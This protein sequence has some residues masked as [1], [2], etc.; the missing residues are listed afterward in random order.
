MTQKLLTISVLVSG[1]TDT[2]FRCLD[3]LQPLMNTIDSELIL[4]DTGCDAKMRK[5]LETYADKIISFKWCDDFSKARNVGLTEASGKWFLYLDDDEWFVEVQ[6]LIDF[7]QSGEYRNYTS[8]SYIQRNYLDMEGS[9]FTD[10][11]VG[12]MAQI[13]PELHFQSRIHEYLTPVGTRNKN[14]TATVEHYGYVYATEKQKLDHF[15]RNQT[16]LEEMIKE[17]PDILRWRL[18]LLQ[19][20]R[21]ID[22]YTQMEQLGADGIIK[23]NGSD[24]SDDEEA[25]VY[26][27]SFYAARILAAEGCKDYDRMYELCQIAAEDKRNTKLCQTF[28]NEMC[29]KA[30]FYLGLHATD[31][32][33]A[34]EQYI[35]SE[36]YAQRYLDFKEYFEKNKEEFYHLQI[37][38]FVG[39][40][41]DQVKVKEIYSIRICNGLKLNQENNLKIFIER[42][43]WDEKHVYVFEEIVGILIESMENYARI[44]VGKAIPEN[45]EYVVYEKTLQIMHRQHALWEYFCGEIEARQNQGMN[46]NGIIRLIGTIFPNEVEKKDSQS[47]IEKLAAQVKEQIRLLIARGMKEEA[48]SVIQQVKKFIPEDLQLQELEALCAIDGDKNE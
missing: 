21:S 39:E 43:C 20:Y 10:T 6:S 15:R 4:V 36:Q 16:L 37:A 35:L 3:S 38:P 7:F 1:R 33:Y 28:L 25:R 48:E 14:L 13:T 26:S 9:Q 32:V 11:R 23:I 27:G 17:E 41:L 19:E 42:L 29:A 12:R 22:D 45:E 31:S 8:A 40:C 2:T 47:E 24:K 18:Q 44:Y 46:M 30:C 5:Q 34:E